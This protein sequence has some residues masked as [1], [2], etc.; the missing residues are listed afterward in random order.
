MNPDA[1]RKLL[2]ATLPVG[3]TVLISRLTG[4][5]APPSNADWDIAV[6]DKLRY[7]SD[8]NIHFLSACVH[9]SLEYKTCLLKKLHPALK[10]RTGTFPDFNHIKTFNL[11]QLYDI[12][13]EV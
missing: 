9:D 7:L 6:Q 5:L 11:A 12:L 3:E 1:V 13:I 10:T 2:S 4:V 8:E